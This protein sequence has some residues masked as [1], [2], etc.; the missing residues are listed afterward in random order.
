[1]VNRTR[2]DCSDK[3]IDEYNKEFSQNKKSYND[4]VFQNKKTKRWVK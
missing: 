4:F 2:K 3:D 1:M